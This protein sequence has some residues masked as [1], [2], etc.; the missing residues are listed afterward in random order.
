MIW[1]SAW[2]NSIAPERP[3]RDGSGRPGGPSEMASR[4]SDGSTRRDAPPEPDVRVEPEDSVRESA[5][6][7]IFGTEYRISAAAPPGYIADV[8]AH[9]DRMMQ[10]L[11]ERVRLPSTSRLAILTALHI[12]D[13]LFRE[14]AARSDVLTRVE[15]KTEVLRLLL[16]SPDEEPHAS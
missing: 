6:V 11:S 8:A 12:A 5:T 3:R 4:T 9:V 14:R 15:E 16:E 13:E 1:S 2:K 7:S 10:Q